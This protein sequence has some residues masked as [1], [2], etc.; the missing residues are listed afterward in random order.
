LTTDSGAAEGNCT[1]R[2]A[3]FVHPKNVPFPPENPV[4][5]EHAEPGRTAQHTGFAG[6]DCLR[7][8]GDAGAPSRFPRVNPP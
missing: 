6:A 3:N 1:A 5:P 4:S 2:M 8:I 7:K